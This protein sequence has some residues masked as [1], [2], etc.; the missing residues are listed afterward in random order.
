M[1]AIALSLFHLREVPIYIKFI[2]SILTS[3]YNKVIDK[4][5]ETPAASRTFQDLDIH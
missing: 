3:N 1:E 4:G 5:N 2:P